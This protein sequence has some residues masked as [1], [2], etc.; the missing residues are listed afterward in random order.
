MLTFKNFL[1]EEKSI[2]EI[3]PEKHVQILK[4]TDKSIKSHIS[5]GGKHS[6]VAGMRLIDR[7]ETHR[8]ALKEKGYN[9]WKKYCDEM[10]YDYRHDAYDHFA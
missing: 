9:H 7:Y 8:I 2:S 1:Q 4:K 5:R 6:S 10:G 3:T